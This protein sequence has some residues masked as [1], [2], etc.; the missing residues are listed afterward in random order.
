MKRL[1]ITAASVAAMAFGARVEVLHI[2]HILKMPSAY[3]MSDKS[4]L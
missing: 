1:V 2:R 3:I 4:V